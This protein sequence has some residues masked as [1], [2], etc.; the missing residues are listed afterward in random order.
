[1][2]EAM[3][4]GIQVNVNSSDDEYAD[5]A[6]TRGTRLTELMNQNQT[7]KVMWTMLTHGADEPESNIESDVDSVGSWS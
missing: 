1:M 7:L 2:S 5:E 4:D 6:C 3:C